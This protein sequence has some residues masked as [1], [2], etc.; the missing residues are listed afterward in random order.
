LPV[1][2]LCWAMMFGSRGYVHERSIKLLHS[3]ISLPPKFLLL[4][5]FTCMTHEMLGRCK[6]RPFHYFLLMFLDKELRSL[7]RCHC[8]H[9]EFCYVR[10]YVP[11]PFIILHNISKI[12]RIAMLLMLENYLILHNFPGDFLI[13][14]NNYV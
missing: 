6:E 7:F 2:F 11:E 8:I 5:T 13:T 9:I 10:V 14:A 3:F 1:K 4:I 12:R